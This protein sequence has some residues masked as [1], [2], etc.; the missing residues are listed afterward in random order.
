[1]AFSEK[2]KEVK[3]EIK[4]HNKLTTQTHSHMLSIVK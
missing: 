2:S 4:P 1:M 3:E